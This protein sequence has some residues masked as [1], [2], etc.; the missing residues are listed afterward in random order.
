M[1]KLKVL[2]LAKSYKNGGRCIAGKLV[3]F[4][5][6]NAV[7]VGAWVRPVSNG[8]AGNNAMKGEMYRYEDGS[9]V[10]LLDIVEMSVLSH[11]P[12]SGQPE[13]YVI[14]ESQRWRK[15]SRL[16]ARCI[17]SITDNANDI[18]SE[19]GVSSNVVTPMY[20]K[21]GLVSQS[22]YL[23]KPTSLKVT[24]SNNCYNGKYKRSIR[25]G[26]N[27][28][29]ERYENISITCPSICRALTNKYPVEGGAPITMTLMKGDNYVFCMS[30]A[31]LY[32][33]R[34]LHYKLVASV[35]DHDGYLQRRYAS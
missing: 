6:N 15:L 4:T 26:F 30:L 25:A 13:N 23:I 11:S 32:T 8:G 1:Q 18:W 29:G 14:D 28:H 17:G 16:D 10:E 27:Y 3:N 12:M 7:R 33:V 19:T 31:P 2:I 24:L 22:L 9:E 34:N 21:R 20:E 5:E 35:F